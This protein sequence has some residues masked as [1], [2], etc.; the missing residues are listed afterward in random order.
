MFFVL[1]GKKKKASYLSLILPARRTENRDIRRSCENIFQRQDSALTL[2]G[3]GGS[4]M[5]RSML[6]GLYL[7]LSGSHGSPVHILPTRKDA[8]IINQLLVLEVSGYM[9]GQ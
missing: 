9:L 5:A 4:W 2:E 7:Y 6:Y 1:L 8:D 3:S